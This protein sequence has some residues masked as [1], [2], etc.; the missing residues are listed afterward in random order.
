MSVEAAKEAVRDAV[1]RYLADPGSV[2]LHAA[3]KRSLDALADAVGADFW[4]R[5]EPYCPYNRDCDAWRPCS[6]C[7]DS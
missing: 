7:T 5:P 6:A 1:A 4:E 3:A 2:A